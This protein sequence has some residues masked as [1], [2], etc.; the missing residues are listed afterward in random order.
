MNVYKIR[1]RKDNFQSDNVLLY[2]CVFYKDY[3][4][5]FKRIIKNDN[6]K[7]FFSGLKAYNDIKKHVGNLFKKDVIKFNKIAVNI[8]KK[9]S[10]LFLM[11]KNLYR[12]I[13]YSFL[14]IATFSSY[15]IDCLKSK[16]D[17]SQFLL[18]LKL[19]KLLKNF[20]KKKICCDEETGDIFNF[21]PKICCS[22]YLKQNIPKQNEKFFLFHHKD[23]NLIQDSWIYNIHKK[24]LTFF[25]KS[26][27]IIELFFNSQYLGS[28]FIRLKVKRNQSIKLDLV[29]DNKILKKMLESDVSNFKNTVSKSGLKFK[30]ITIQTKNFKKHTV[31]KNNYDFYNRAVNLN[32]FSKFKQQND[33]FCRLLLSEFCSPIISKESIDIYI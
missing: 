25:F 17:F 18:N 30:D 20:F 27:K 2:D 16:N 23:A 1:K 6:T 12:S 13:V 32:N 11:S 3:F 29:S 31:S 33:N 21:F 15:T 8:L 5:S 24:L 7:S 28:L 9:C 14:K 19:S 22:T 26:K 4:C 10:N